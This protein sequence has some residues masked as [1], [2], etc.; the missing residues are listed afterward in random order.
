MTGAVFDTEG[1]R[2]GS[3][4]RITFF[5]LPSFPKLTDESL[6]SDED[7]ET[8]EDLTEPFNIIIKYTRNN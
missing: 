3:Y 4:D 7:S 8:D 2:W 1:N 5:R 6:Q